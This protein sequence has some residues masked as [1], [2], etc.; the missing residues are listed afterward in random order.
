MS[1]IRQNIEKIT[2]EI[3]E[4][5]IKAGRKPE[6]VKLMAVTKT[7][8]VICVEEAYQAGARLFGENRVNELSDKFSL[9]R[10]GSSVHLIGHLQRNKT[11]IAVRYAD[12]IDSVDKYDT[13]FEIDKHSKALNKIMDILLEYNTSGEESKSGFIS[14]KD[15]FEAVDRIRELGF[16]RIKGLMTIAPFTDSEKEISSSFRKLSS[17]YNSLSVKHP[18]LPLETLSM[19]M[20]SDFRIAIEEG[21]NII[22]IGTGIFGER[23]Y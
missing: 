20:S 12:S 19:G 4:A 22:R 15:F 23:N 11:K 17:L 3:K 2:E 10:E 1:E 13:A 14:E 6:S 5:A 8:P 7:K 16:V 9:K 21:S 18:D